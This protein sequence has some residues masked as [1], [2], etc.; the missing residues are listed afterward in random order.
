M[1]DTESQ[2]IGYFIWTTVGMPRNVSSFQPQQLILQTNIVAADSTLMV[3]GSDDIRPK[4]G[5]AGSSF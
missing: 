5:I 1:D 4:V 2:T 3:V